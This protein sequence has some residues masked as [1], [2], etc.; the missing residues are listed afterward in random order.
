VRVVLQR[1]T[2][3]RVRAGGEEVGAIGPGLV[4]ALSAVL[5]DA[6]D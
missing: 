1:V 5:A 6:H 3:A 4:R 2:R